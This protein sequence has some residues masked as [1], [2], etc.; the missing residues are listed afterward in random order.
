MMGRCLLPAQTLLLLRSVP[1]VLNSQRLLC[2]E[3]ETYDIIILSL[4]I[5]PH[6]FLQDG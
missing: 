4:S 1:P 2:K 6:D 3:R 5:R